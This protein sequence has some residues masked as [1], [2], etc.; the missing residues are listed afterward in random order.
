LEP[1]TATVAAT[2]NDDGP[3][4]AIIFSS[5]H[6]LRLL[7][8]TEIFI[9]L[10]SASISADTDDLY[11]GY[12]SNIDSIDDTL[13]PS[14]VPSLELSF[15]S[16]YV[17]SLKRI[18]IP[19]AIPSMVPSLEPST[20]P[21][22]VPNELVI[23][24]VITITTA[25]HFNLLSS[26]KPSLR[27]NTTALSF[28]VPSSIPSSNIRPRLKSSLLTSY[29]STAA[30]DTDIKSYLKNYYYRRSN[31]YDDSPSKA[32]IF[33]SCHN[34]RLP[35]GMEIFVLLLA[36]HNSEPSAVLSSVPSAIPSMEPKYETQFE[37]KYCSNLSAK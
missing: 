23:F 26:T 25:R 33:S 16:S 30:T 19:S 3:T 27:S 9:L 1:S 13:S 4:K 20:A 21:I 37:S 18:S 2:D 15:D 6:N 35:V 28:P 31:V 24:F 12:D 29:F 22:S 5:C 34:L 11:Y 14:S 32:I 7:V 36:T 8:G 10:S 17:L